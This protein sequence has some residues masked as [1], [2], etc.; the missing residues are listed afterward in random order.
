MTEKIAENIV[1]NGVKPEIIQ[2]II[3]SST[4]IETYKKN[5]TL[6]EPQNKE[7]DIFFILS[8]TVRLSLLSENGD[9]VSYND[10]QENDFFGW[11]SILDGKERLTS[12]TTH[13]PCNII[14]I[15]G[16]KFKQLL[17]TDNTLMSNF[18]LRI[19]SV[20]RNYTQRI[21]DLSILSVKHRILS[22]INKRNKNSTNIVDLGTHEELSSWLGTSRETVTR[23][24]RELESETI[25]KRSGSHYRILNNDKIVKWGD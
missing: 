16:H 15:S 18:M 1:F 8:G 3:E 2:K 24:L 22:E 17:F 25:I 14:R 6:I 5:Q 11:L 19:G 12:A 9:V 10:V 13:T 23:V 4:P 21:E 20:I 7:Q